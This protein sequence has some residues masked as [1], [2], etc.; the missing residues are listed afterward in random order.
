VQDQVS[1]MNPRAL[2]AS[3]NMIDDPSL[4]KRIMDS[5]MD[6]LKQKKL[7]I[8]K[9]SLEQLCELV[10]AVAEH[11]PEDLSVFYEYIETGLESGFFKNMRRLEF[12]KLQ[13]MFCL[14]SDRG[15]ISRQGAEVENPSKFYTVFLLALKDQLFDPTKK[16]E[17]IAKV[18]AARNKKHVKRNV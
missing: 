9:F 17:R 7:N 11:R 3:L 6:N 18:E 12:K 10:D 4:K 14:F 8:R 15:F 1:T 16:D 13:K 2:F 5:I